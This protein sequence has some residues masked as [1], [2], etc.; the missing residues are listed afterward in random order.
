L[1]KQFDNLARKA[2]LILVLALAMA[3]VAASAQGKNSNS[4]TSKKSTPRLAIT[5]GG[6]LSSGQVNVVYQTVLTAQGGITPYNWQIF[7]GALPPGIGL[8]ASTGSLA[9]TPALAGSY[10]F[11]IKVADSGNQSDKQTFALAIAAAVLAP[12]PLAITTNSLPAGTAGL[13]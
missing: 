9:G 1:I 7:S 5:S 2:S 6:N 4:G 8:N 11:T 12:N 3:G 13:S 10:S